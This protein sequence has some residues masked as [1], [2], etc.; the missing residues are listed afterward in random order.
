MLRSSAQNVAPGVLLLDLPLLAKQ[1]GGLRTTSC[2]F[3]RQRLLTKKY[4]TS[5]DLAVVILDKNGNT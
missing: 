1:V 5:S 2:D 3:N 4:W